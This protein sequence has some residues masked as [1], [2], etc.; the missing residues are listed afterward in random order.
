VPPHGKREALKKSRIQ[1]FRSKGLQGGEGFESVVFSQTGIGEDSKGNAKK[2]EKL[3]E[4]GK[5]SR[6]KRKK[7]GEG[8]NRGSEFGRERGRPRRS[9]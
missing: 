5:D 2:K 9:W 8:S 6:D 3:P 7:G 1:E 4:K